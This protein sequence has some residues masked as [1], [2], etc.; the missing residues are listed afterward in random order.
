[1]V[2]DYDLSSLAAKA[3][4]MAGYAVCLSLEEGSQVSTIFQELQAASFKDLETIRSGGLVPLR[5]A[6]FFYEGST[7]F[8][9]VGSALFAEVKVISIEKDPPLYAKLEL[10]LVAWRSI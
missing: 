1:M 3:L 7:Y 9:K 4:S 10:E 6:S 8:I 5:D 2:L